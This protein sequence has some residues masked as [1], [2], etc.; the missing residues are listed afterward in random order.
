[1][2]SNATNGRMLVFLTPNE[3]KKIRRKFGGNEN[4]M[5]YAWHT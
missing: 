2:N 4:V 5:G 3:R 1:M